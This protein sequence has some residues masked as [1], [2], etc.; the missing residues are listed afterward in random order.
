MEIVD[1]T[2]RES[3][4]RDN[5]ISFKLG[6]EII[7]RLSMAGVDYIEIGYLKK[8]YDTKS[9]FMNYNKNY[10]EKAYL[11]SMKRSKLSAM[12][13]LEDFYSNNWDLQTIKKLSLIRICI[14]GKTM[15]QTKPLVDF[16]H[17]L[18]IKVSIHLIRSNFYTIKK[19]IAIAKIAMKNG[20][21]FFYIADTNGNLLPEEVKRYTSALA[22]NVS[23]NIR[24]GF[25]PHENLGL[26]QIIAL[27]ALENGATIIDSSM[28]GFGKGAGNLRTELFPLLLMRKNMLKKGKY[29]IKELFSLARY[30]NHKITKINSF[31]EQYKYSL[32]GTKN[33]GLDAD[34]EIKKLALANNIKDYDLAFIFT[35]ECNCDLE[36]LKGLLN[37]K[38]RNI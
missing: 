5:P 18:G 35:N 36:K 8:N 24:I 33:V 4:Y 27:T 12:I 25:H 23:N 30:F 38:K 6:L 16:F 7:R 21:D 37:N 10:I 13:H 29:D 32:Y 1:V 31:E 15:A 2:L 11:S 20:A 14:D 26:S 22:E 28:L 9:L 17:R 19:C 3:V 34:K